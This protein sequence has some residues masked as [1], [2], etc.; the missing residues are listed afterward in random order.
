MTTLTNCSCAD[1]SSPAASSQRLRN[2]TQPPVQEAEALAN[3]SAPAPDAPPQQP[4]RRLPA[5][6]QRGSTRLPSALGTPGDL[7]AVLINE[8]VHLTLGP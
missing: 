8:S 3:P 1:D 7:Q 4:R 6:L 5:S 2:E